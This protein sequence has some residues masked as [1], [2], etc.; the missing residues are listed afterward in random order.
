MKTYISTG[1][2]DMMALDAVIS[3]EEKKSISEFY[4]ASRFGPS[5]IPLFDSNSEYPNIKRHHK[6]DD[7]V[8]MKAMATLD[9][10]AVPFWHFRPDFHP[11]FEVGLKLFG[12]ENDEI[13]VIDVIERFRNVTQDVR[14]GNKL[15][16][17]YY[18]SSF[19][20]NAKKPDIHESY[21][22]FHY[23]TSTRPRHDISSIDQSD[24]KFVESLSCNKGLKV[25]V[26]S[27]CQID[28]P[29][30][31][32]ELLVN[33]SIKTIIDL[34]SYCEY[35]AGCDS[36]CGILSTK[37]LPK[38]RIYM[39]THDKNIKTNILNNPGYLYCYFLP[40]TPEDI[41]HFYKPYIGEP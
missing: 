32:Y 37:R 17:F 9:P 39:K 18:G 19:I 1:I 13:Q 40:H 34:V 28:V 30:S 38:E 22:L 4:W 36:F 21:I 35:Y 41:I 14:L 12:I 20:R 16:N 5:L 10:V 15:D 23:P 11:N 7:D 8:G 25:V 3:P 33:P 2:G 31:N 24:W 26:I 27:D 6:I 29:L